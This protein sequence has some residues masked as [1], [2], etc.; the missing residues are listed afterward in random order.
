MA[1]KENSKENSKSDEDILKVARER[2]KIADEAETQIRILAKE[3][4][5]FRAGKQWP[6]D[7]KKRHSF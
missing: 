5:E 6:D 2:F 7:V 3:D 4:L 1:T